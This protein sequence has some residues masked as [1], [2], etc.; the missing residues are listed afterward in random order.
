MPCLL[1]EKRIALGAGYY[2]NNQSYGY[3]ECHLR[4]I[5]GT[6]DAVVRGDTDYVSS[7]VSSFSRVGPAYE[8]TPSLVPCLCTYLLEILLS[9]R[10][11]LFV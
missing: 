4:S 9:F 5:N 10:C 3:G 2:V 7:V 6:L 11:Q 8:Q 1:T